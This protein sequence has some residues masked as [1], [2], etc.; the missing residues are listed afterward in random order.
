MASPACE[1]PEQLCQRNA[2][3]AVPYITGQFKSLSNVGWY[4]AAYQLS[5]AALQPLTGK[6]YANFST[7]WTFFVSLAESSAV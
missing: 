1:D 5:S 3:Q 6:F 2:S 4:G 7:K